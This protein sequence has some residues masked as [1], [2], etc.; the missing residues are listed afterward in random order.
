MDIALKSLAFFVVWGAALLGIAENALAANCNASNITAFTATSP[1]LGSYSPFTTP[2]IVRV[3]LKITANKSC[4]IGVSVKAGS[5]PAKMT[6]PGG[7][8]LNFTVESS[9]SGGSTLIYTAATPAPGNI[10]NLSFGAG[11]G[12]L[13]SDIYVRA[14]SG[15]VVNEGIYPSTPDLSIT[16]DIYDMQGAI[17]SVPLKSITLGASATVIKACKLDPPSLTSLNF[18]SAIINGRASPGVTKTTSFTNVQCTAPTIVRLSGAALQPVSAIAAPSNFDNVI[19]WKAVGTFGGATS[20]LTATAS[21][22]TTADST[23]KNAASGATSNGT[24]GV[25]VN[26]LDSGKPILAGTYSG[27]LTVTIDPTL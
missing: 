18:N 27:V 3:G 15:L 24:I 8:Q 25:T 13:T 22:P 20:T 6:G 10:L 7:N 19:G 1:N 14:L 21:T 4:T 17:S 2:N 23:T 12:T 16:I 5:S 26:L 9:S 11:G